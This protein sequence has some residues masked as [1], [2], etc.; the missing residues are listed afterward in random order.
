MARGQARRL[1]LRA[2]LRAAI[3]HGVLLRAAKSPNDETVP[4]GRSQ[5]IAE[6]WLGICLLCNPRVF[7]Q[8]TSPGPSLSARQAG[9]LF[10]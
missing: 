3:T 4:V 9:W 8:R 10:R 6:E 1:N 5:S 7:F 2:D